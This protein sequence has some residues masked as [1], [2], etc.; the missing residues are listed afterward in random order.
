MNVFIDANIYL[1]FFHLSNEDLE[2][3]Q[4]ALVLHQH[5]KITIWLP[6]QVRDEFIRNRHVKIA[7][8]LRRFGEEKLN[9]QLPQMMKGYEEFSTLK[10]ASKVFTEAKN[11]LREKLLADIESKS[12]KADQIVSKI[13]ENATKVEV[14]QSIFQRGKIRAERGNPPGKNGSYGDAIN[15][16]CLLEAIPNREDLYV[17]SEDGDFFSPLNKDRSNQFLV[18]EWSRQK[19][20]EFRLYQRLSKFLAAYFPDAIL[21]TE[22]EKECAIEELAASPNFARTHNLIAKLQGFSEFT[23][24]QVN[25]ILDAVISNDQVNWI[26]AD[27]DVEQFVRKILENYETTAALEKV[28]KV[29][30]MLSKPEKV[31]D[32]LIF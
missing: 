29:K 22:L 3:L 5:Q 16:E 20:S 2:E 10:E 9:N 26:I 19:N 18:E 11:K 24:T 4:K 23:N 12:L 31:D 30:E 13:F 21:A 8:A 15:W 6:D 27:D 14:D 25:D 17:I 32:D 1:S 7:D 28:A